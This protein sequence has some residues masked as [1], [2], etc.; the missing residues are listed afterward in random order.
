MKNHE[1]EWGDDEFDSDDPICTLCD[2]P[3]SNHPQEKVG[4]YHEDERITLY[5]NRWVDVYGNIRAGDD[6]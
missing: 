6:W 3:Y 4:I 2:T 5:D 1:M